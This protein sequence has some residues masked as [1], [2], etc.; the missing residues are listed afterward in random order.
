MAK[1]NVVSILFYQ[2]LWDRLISNMC[3][4]GF[5]FRGAGLALGSSNCAPS[6]DFSTSI[7]T[8]GQS[9]VCNYMCSDMWIRGIFWPSFVFLSRLY[10]YFYR[11]HGSN[12]G[13]DTWISAQ[14][15]EH[16]CPPCHNVTPYDANIANKYDVEFDRLSDPLDF[17]QAFGNLLQS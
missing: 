14:V 2:K 11:L 4:V 7:R 17:Y 15:S 13:G 5:L 3:F 16:S 6:I 10:P 9:R 1:K 8:R 12:Y